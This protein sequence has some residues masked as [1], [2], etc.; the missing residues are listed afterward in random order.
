MTI[1]T[2]MLILLLTF[3]VAG[4]VERL[5]QSPRYRPRGSRVG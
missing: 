3:G 2:L 5:M 1:S 4:V